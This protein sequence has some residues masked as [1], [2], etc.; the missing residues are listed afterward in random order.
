MMLADRIEGKWID[1]FTEVIGRCGVKPGDTAAILSETQSRPLNV[2]LAELALLRLGARPFHIML[3]T[4]RNPHPVPLRSTGASTVI[5]GLEPVIA[6]LSQAGF[7]V[8][9]TVEG[10]MHAPE[11]PAILKSGARILSISNE[12]PEALERMRPDPRLEQQV[13]AAARLARASRRMTVTS[14]AGTDLT[15][16]MEGASTVGVWGWTEKPGT[17]AHWPGGI[18]VSFPATGTVNGTLVLDR[19]DI[20][21]TFKRYLESPI[22]LTLVDDYITDIAG[23]GTDATLMRRYL[24]AWGDREAYA[25]SHVG[26]GM[27]P[28]ARYEALTM[29]DQRDTNGT[30]LRAVPGNFLFSTGANEF[31]GRF[32]AGHFDIPV[33]NT[34]ITLDGTVVVKDGA[35]QDVFG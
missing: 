20:N 26:W 11:T 15:I 5:A 33:M 23:E 35:L 9:C 28:G 25:V 18:V 22:R 13:R 21:L 17:L 31:A 6:A 12:H 27:N 14:A 34:T 29:Y 24:E 1:A 2:H 4:P 10:P 30:E 3:P 8:D 7:I 19:G 16:A 32:T